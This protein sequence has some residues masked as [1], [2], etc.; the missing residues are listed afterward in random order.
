MDA[1]KDVGHRRK[2]DSQHRDQMSFVTFC[3]AAEEG[4]N[5]I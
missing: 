2:N 4:R 3:K 1:R 5:K